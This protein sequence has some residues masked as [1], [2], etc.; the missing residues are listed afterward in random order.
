MAAYHRS[1]LQRTK[2]KY[3]TLL[4]CSFYFSAAIFLYLYTQY[5]KRKEGIVIVYGYFIGT[6]EDHLRTVSFT[7]T[8]DVGKEKD[9]F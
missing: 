9:V 7:V 1:V 4:S 2:T 3:S 8:N 6:L 5:I